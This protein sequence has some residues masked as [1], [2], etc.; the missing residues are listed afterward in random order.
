VTIKTRIATLAVVLL[1]ALGV[2]AIAASPAYA[3][4]S[5]CD[6]GN[7]CLY[8]GVGGAGTPYEVDATGWPNFTC[9][10]MGTSGR[11]MA[12]SLYNRAP[13]TRIW[14]FNRTSCQEAWGVV[15]TFGQQRSPLNGT[16]NNN[17]ESVLICYTLQVNCR[18][19]DSPSEIV[20]PEDYVHVHY[21]KEQDA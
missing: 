3:A 17:I 6:Y 14:Y 12:S 11:N 13:D 2:G 10:T 1:A 18:N 21:R 20:T 4:W 16:N 19:S 5:D 9:I 8:N 7:T 15:L